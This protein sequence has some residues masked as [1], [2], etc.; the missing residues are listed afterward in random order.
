MTAVAPSRIPRVVAGRPCASRGEARRR[1]T[2]RSRRVVTPRGEVDGAVVVSSEGRIESVTEGTISTEAPETVDVGE[3]A[4]LPGGVDSHVH[5]N[6]PGRTEWE[7]FVAGT[8][9][10]AAGGVTTLVDMPLNSEPTTVDVAAFAAKLEAAEG[11]RRRGHLLADVAFWGGLVPRSAPRLEALW[12]QGVAGF[13]AFMADS[14][15][16]SF[17]PVERTDL[18]PAMRSLAELGAPLLVHA[19]V[20]TTAPPPAGRVADPQSY[21]TWLAARPPRFEVDAVRSL[22]ELVEQTG[23]RVHVV[24]VAAADVVPMIREAKASGL[25][26]T[27]E[28]C[29]HYLFFDAENVPDGDPRFKCAPPIRGRRHREALWA[30]LLDGTL[31]LVAS[32]HSPAPPSM[33]TGSL[34]SAWGGI[35]SLEVAR[36]ALWTEARRRGATLSDLAR[37]TSEAPARLAGLPERG[38]IV[39]GAAAD[40]VVFDP[41]APWRVRDAALHHRQPGSAYD[42][43]ELVGRVEATYLGGR[44]VWPP[45]EA[46]R[47]G[48]MAELSAGE[49]AGRETL[50]S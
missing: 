3:L 1:W 15:V 45:G 36:I 24:H 34:L 19:E 18:L 30:A 44:S 50:E 25:P 38:A 43:S 16:D 26:V 40:L 20:V 39:P 10:A 46:R 37:W 11:H 31:D 4:V 33:K 2:L 6:E 29:P 48:E 23:C 32:D 28:T 12:R 17:P 7:G 21:A 22:L 35:L 13:K 49:P 27:A 5:L 9:A 42:G 41:D 47:P 8:R 14:G